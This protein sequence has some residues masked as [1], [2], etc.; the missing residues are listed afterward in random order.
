M[1][2]EFSGGRAKNVIGV[3]VCTKV[4]VHTFVNVSTAQNITYLTKSGSLI[5]VTR[6][7]TFVDEILT[8]FL[9]SFELPV[10]PTCL[11]S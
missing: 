4:K 10:P 5:L 2:G 3:K 6:F 1:P 11:L 9:V 7:S 8:G